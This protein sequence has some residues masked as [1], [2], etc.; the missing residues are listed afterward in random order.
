MFGS[1]GLFVCLLVLGDLSLNSDV[2]KC[3]STLTEASDW[4]MHFLVSLEKIESSQQ[5]PPSVEE[6]HLWTGKR[7]KGLA[8]GAE[9]TRGDESAQ[10]RW[11]F[12]GVRLWL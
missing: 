6:V 7:T 3:L 9:L 5:P 1:C 12:E 8:G 2:S 4:L 11:T 10:D